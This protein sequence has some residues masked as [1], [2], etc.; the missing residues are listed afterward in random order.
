MT[1]KDW[2]MLGRL[3]TGASTMAMLLLAY[4]LAGGA[5]LS[6]MTVVLALL[7]LGIHWVGFVLNDIADYEVDKKDPARQHFPLIAGRITY[8]QACFG[9][10]LVVGF[11]MSVGIYLSGWRLLPIWAWTGGVLFGVAYNA[12]RRIRAWILPFMPLSALCFFIWA[13]YL[14]SQAFPPVF[15][16]ASLYAFFLMLFMTSVSNHIRDISSDVKVCLMRSLGFRVER[17]ELITST[18]GL[19]Y[20]WT[21]RIT[22]GCLGLFIALIYENAAYIAL[23]LL[24]FCATI[25]ATKKLTENGKFDRRVKYCAAVEVLTYLGLVWCCAGIYCWMIAL[26]LTVMPVAFFV[27]M[28]IYLW[29][30]LLVP[31]T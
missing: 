11:L 30:T 31:K 1:V 23:Y 13:Y 12:G 24:I 27:L 3:H 10:G 21:L 7:G 14:G 25:I 29:Q 5:L 9:C 8:P 18:A 16:L 22:I 17:G 6:W 2:F 26:F 28:N 15:W 4:F 20:V 19:A